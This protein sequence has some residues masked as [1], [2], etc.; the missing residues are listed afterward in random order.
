MGWFPLKVNI[1]FSCNPCGSPGK[2]SACNV[3]DLGLSPELGGSPEER[4]HNP[5]QY[6][7]LENFMDCISP[8]G[9]RVGRDWVTF[10]FIFLIQPRISILRWNLS[11]IK[12][13]AHIKTWTAMFVEYLLIITKKWKQIKCHSAG[14]FNLKKKKKKAKALVCLCNKTKTKTKTKTTY[15]SN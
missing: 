2:E 6:S 5:L 3:G 7:G 4:N 14:V 12:A 10:T 8:W 11:E 1:D 13:Y 9:H 15:K